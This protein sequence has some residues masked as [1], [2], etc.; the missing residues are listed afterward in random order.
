MNVRQKLWK[1]E[2]CVR[3]HL[4]PFAARVF[5]WAKTTTERKKNPENNN[6]NNNKNNNQQS[7]KRV[8]AEQ[9]SEST[10]AL[11]SSGCVSFDKMMLIWRGFHKPQNDLHLHFPI[12][13]HS[14]RSIHLWVCLH[15]RL[16]FSPSRS[17]CS[18]LCFAASRSHPISV[19]VCL[20]V[21]FEVLLMNKCERPAKAFT[22]F[23]P[24]LSIALTLFR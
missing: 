12:S 6:N 19:Y 5:I 13:L 3:A 22:F 15:V 16:D 7:K 1:S 14:L 11:N 23:F 20:C 18:L 10:L 21:S 2:T 9:G 8:N 17:R 24:V 4:P